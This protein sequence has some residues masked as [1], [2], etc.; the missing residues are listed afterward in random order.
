MAEEGGAHG[1]SAAEAGGAFDRRRA[2][3]TLPQFVLRRRRPGANAERL[4]P[5]KLSAVGISGVAHGGR[6]PRAWYLHPRAWVTAILVGV[7]V[8]VGIWQVHAQ[9][10]KRQADLVS[11][12]ERV[13]VEY[14]RKLHRQVIAST[15]ATFA[16]ASVVQAFHGNV[17]TEQF[18]TVADQL[19]EGF[20]G[21][22]H[23][24]LMPGGVSTAVFPYNERTR[25]TL[26]ISLLVFPPRRAEVLAELA[27]FPERRATVTGP[28]PLLLLGELGIV[29][30]HPIYTTDAPQFLD[31]EPYLFKPTNATFEV[32]CS[33]EALR[34]ENCY[35]PGPDT[36]DGEPT[37][38]W[39]LTTILASVDDL[40]RPSGLH[41]LEDRVVGELSG[42]N[43]QVID[44]QKHP[45]LEQQ[46]GIFA[47]SES[48]PANATMDGVVEGNVSIPELGIDWAILV[49][50]K[51]GWPLTSD[52]FVLQLALIALFTV[53]GGIGMGCVIIGGVRHDYI[54]RLSNEMAAR[55][56]TAA[57][58]ARSRL[59]RT[60][61]HDLR[62]PLM[63]VS[64]L[65]RALLSTDPEADVL[66]VPRAHMQAVKECSALCEGI[67]S[68]MLGARRAAQVA[69]GGGA[70][71]AAPSPRAQPAPARPPMRVCVCVCV[72]QILSEW[73]RADSSWCSCP[74]AWPSC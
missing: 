24:Q 66:S 43:W 64:S 15:S 6:M 47:A 5:G 42:F 16:L 11:E 74:S 59:I 57:A 70:A 23:I 3:W 8:G 7:I 63:S 36:A 22:T 9:E 26:G 30:R 49:A 72:R 54:S 61:M 18:H 39:G 62:S 65:S 34:R 27:A 71:A 28:R 44:R 69:L 73:R 1:S 51:E 41:R 37:R 33:T 68:D 52:G 20:S 50:P 35:F 58:T 4:A 55:E 10:S 14:A 53:V 46:D 17:T 2:V 31:L 56:A 12:V 48:A 60:V 45:T 38:L 21:I 13:V 67:V 19:I 40:L 25:R 32:D 29:I